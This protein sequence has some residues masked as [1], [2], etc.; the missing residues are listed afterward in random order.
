VIARSS[1][2]RFSI[3]CMIRSRVGLSMPH[4]PKSVAMSQGFAPRQPRRSSATRLSQ[5][6]RPYPADGTVVRGYAT[7]AISVIAGGA[8]LGITNLQ[9][10]PYT[11]WVKGR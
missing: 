8:S 10:V 3:S 11:N 6:L 5:R 7:G 1:R 2:L 4:L 9:A